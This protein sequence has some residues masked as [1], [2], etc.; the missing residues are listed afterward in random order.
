[1]TA[2]A[3]LIASVIIASSLDGVGNALRGVAKAIKEK[4]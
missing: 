3:I 2:F 4:Q 1:M